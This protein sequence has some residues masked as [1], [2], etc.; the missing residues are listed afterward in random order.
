LAA[1]RAFD[2]LAKAQLRILSVSL[3]AKDP[4]ELIQK[5]P[6]AFRTAILEHVEPYLDGVIARLKA[7]PDRKEPSGKQRIAAT[8]FPLLQALPTS[9][10][11][12]AYLEKAATEFGMVESEF[13][14]DFRSATESDRTLTPR[15]Q[16]VPETAEKGFDRIELTLGL[17]LLYPSSR[18]LLK[19]LI[20]IEQADLEQVR[21]A[22]IAAPLSSEAL[23]ILLPLP[24][25][26]I[27]RERLQVVALYCEEHFPQWSDS[28]AEKEIRKMCA[29]A[30]REQIVRHQAQIIA[31]LK[32]ARSAGR[33]DEEA[34]LLMQYQKLLT[35][36]RMT[37]KQ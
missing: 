26:P 20:P 25:E 30:N 22:I 7:L 15:R 32:E 37:A 13:A 28:L 4:D 5:D 8:L 1:G 14:A 23:A 36:T 31:A 6:V 29:A 18:S 34:K 10:E 11:L 9:V 12:R 21:L 17:A 16:T 2:L 35:L 3:P 27:V 19:E 24:I 33:S